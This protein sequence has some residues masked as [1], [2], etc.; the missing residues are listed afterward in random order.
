M[1][2]TPFPA[3]AAF[4]ELPPAAALELPPLPPLAAD[5]VAPP[6]EPVTVEPP[7]DP[8]LPV[9]AGVAAAPPAF[10]PPPKYLAHGSEKEAMSVSSGEESSVTEARRAVY[11]REGQRV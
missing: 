8:P 3:E 10:P 7:L 6:I 1:N 2:P 4:D 11:R 5:P 9:G